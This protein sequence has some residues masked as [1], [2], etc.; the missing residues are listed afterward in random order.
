LKKKTLIVF[1]V[2]LSIIIGIITGVYTV[3]SDNI[4]NKMNNNQS[5]VFTSDNMV[6]EGWQKNE[7]SYISTTKDPSVTLYDINSYVNNIYF[8]GTLSQYESATIKIFY[9]T[10]KGEAFTEEKSFLSIVELKGQ[11]VYFSVNKN[12]YDIK[13]QL[14][15]EAGLTS[16]INTFEINPQYINFSF[17]NIF[18]FVTILLMIVIALGLFINRNSFKGYYKVFKKYKSLLTNLIERDLKV[19]YRRSVLGLL[20][21]ILNPLLMML[22]ITAVFANVFKFN[23]K[24]F[25]IY[26]ITGAWI[27]NFVSESTTLS[28]TS[29]IGAAPLIKKVYIPKYIF[30]LQKCLYSVVNMLFTL[31]AVAIVFLILQIQLHWTILLFPIPMIYAFV[32][33][34]GLSFI[35]SSVNVFFRDVGHLYSVWITAWMYFT[36]IIYP[37][38]AL[39]AAMISILKLNPLYYYVQYARDVLIYGTIPSLQQNIICIG[40]SVVTLVIGLLLF[41]KTQD[42]FIL[43]I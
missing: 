24:D 10:E 25:P 34:L 16:K 22:V 17:A 2:I 11:K 15:N 5:H 29:V 43:Y 12:V 37:I 8:N 38:S 18:S 21:S 7:T 13:I 28:L 35:L 41:K 6:F 42:K 19:K 26:Y 31:I 39:P 40:F 30:P 32:F 4:S 3:S 9:T 20:W 1:L 36:P 14:Y 23:I 27:F 33:S